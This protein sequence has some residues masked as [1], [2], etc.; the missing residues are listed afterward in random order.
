MNQVMPVL[1]VVGQIA[2]DPAVV[3]MGVAVQVRAT[4][5]VRAAVG[6]RAVVSVQAMVNAVLTEVTAIDRRE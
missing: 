4:T 2:P 6:V 1:V 5:V 3:L